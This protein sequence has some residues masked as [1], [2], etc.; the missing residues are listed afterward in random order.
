MY[1]SSGNTSPA[2]HLSLFQ[3][4]DLIDKQLGKVEQ[5]VDA[6]LLVGGFAGSEYLFHRVDVSDLSTSKLDAHSRETDGH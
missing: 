4:L 1:L 3:V 5:G 2:V 6:L